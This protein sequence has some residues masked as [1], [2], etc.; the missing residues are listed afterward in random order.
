MKITP[1]WNDQ[2]RNLS[3]ILWKPSLNSKPDSHKA[4]HWNCNNKNISFSVYNAS[5]NITNN[6][7]FKPIPEINNTA[8]KKRVFFRMFSA[9]ITRFS[10]FINKNDIT[11][12]Q[13]VCYLKRLIKIKSASDDIKNIQLKHKFFFKNIKTEY[14]PIKSSITNKSVNYDLFNPHFIQVEKIF[15][16]MALCDNVIYCK[17]VKL[18]LYE[19]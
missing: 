19:Q 15:T 9:E 13:V 14:F 16:K 8:E 18:F 17:K 4:E 10:K 7:T 3:D 2:C 12:P 6:L 11:K 5:P 1:F